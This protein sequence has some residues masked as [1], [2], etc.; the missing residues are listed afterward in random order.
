MLKEGYLDYLDFI[1]ST[2]AMQVLQQDRNTGLKL[3]YKFE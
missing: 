2:A 1:Q 3:E